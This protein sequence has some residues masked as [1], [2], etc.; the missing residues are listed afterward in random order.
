MGWEMGEGW[1]SRGLWGLGIELK[2]VFSF[3]LKLGYGEMGFGVDDIIVYI[4]VD[5]GFVWGEVEVRKYDRSCYCKRC[6]WRWYW[7]GLENGGS[8][9]GINGIDESEREMGGLVNVLSV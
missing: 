3:I 9:C 8:R 4:W 5:N 6:I 7:F 1:V 2:F